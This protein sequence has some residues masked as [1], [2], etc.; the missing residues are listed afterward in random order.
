MKKLFISY[1]C[2]SVCNKFYCSTLF[3]LQVIENI[4]IDFDSL[5]CYLNNIYPNWKNVKIIILEGDS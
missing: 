4:K 1:I 3:L 5:N 2:E